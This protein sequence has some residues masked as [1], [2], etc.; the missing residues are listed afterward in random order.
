MPTREPPKGKDPGTKKTARKKAVKKTAK[1]TAKK[2]ARRS[3]NR[4][5][6]AA[7]R[8]RLDRARAR[9]I[10]L[11]PAVMDEL[12]A[13]SLERFV[14]LGLLQE[15]N[16]LF[17]NPRG[18]SMTLRLTRRGFDGNLLGHPAVMFDRI[19][20]GREQPEGM[21]FARVLE[22]PDAKLK[23]DRVERMRVE[24]GRTRAAEYGWSVQPIEIDDD[25]S[26]GQ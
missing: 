1:K 3:P 7:E 26:G 10:T 22:E 16:R 4:R 15:I 17:L 19:V 18:L 11:R 21:V 13:M 6:A 2:A 12:P 20:D 8:A 5:D 24:A 25:D 14:E 9:T 23:R